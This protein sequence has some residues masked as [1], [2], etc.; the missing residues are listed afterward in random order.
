MEQCDYTV[1]G[2]IGPQGSGKSTILS[3]LYSSLDDN[4]VDR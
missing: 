1:V 2:V 3:W 4:A